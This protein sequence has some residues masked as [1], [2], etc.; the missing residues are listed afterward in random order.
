MSWNYRVFRT[1]S[2]HPITGD[3]FSWYDIREAYYNGNPEPSGYSL[4]PDPV[5]GNSLEELQWQLQSMLE[6]ISK[7]VVDIE[8]NDDE[9]MNY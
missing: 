5:C 9:E 2:V 8:K 3:E 6:A 4:T 7:P 1:T